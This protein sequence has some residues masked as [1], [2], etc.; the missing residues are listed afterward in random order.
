MG[1]A[2]TAAKATGSPVQFIGID[3]NDPLT[4]SAKSFVKQSEVSYPVGSDPTLRVSSVL[5]TENGLPTTFFIDGSGHVIGVNRGP[6]NA[7]QLAQWMKRLT[8]GGSAS[9]PAPDKRP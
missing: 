1:N 7:T 6:L 4:S 2:S 9:G 5:Y 3:V 8:G